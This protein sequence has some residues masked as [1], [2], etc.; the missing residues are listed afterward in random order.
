MCNKICSHTQIKDLAFQCNTVL[1]SRTLK[2]I[3]AIYT[4]A[5]VKQIAVFSYNSKEQ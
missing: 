1:V 5:K 2:Q 3:T 4:L